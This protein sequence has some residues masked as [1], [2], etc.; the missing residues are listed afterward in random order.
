MAINLIVNV[1]PGTKVSLGRVNV[2]LEPLYDDSF[3]DA[4]PF[5]EVQ[6]I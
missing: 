2:M 4:Y 5:P 1:T 6:A 3:L